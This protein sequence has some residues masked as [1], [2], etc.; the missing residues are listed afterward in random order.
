MFFVDVET[1]GLQ[2]WSVLPPLFNAI[3]PIQ[4][5]VGCNI[6]I[7]KSLCY[8]FERTWDTSGLICVL[9][10]QNEFAVVLPRPKIFVERSSKTT[11]VQKTGWAWSKPGS[12]FCH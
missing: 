4:A 7:R 11:N 10:T 6:K 12:Y 5:L 2:I 3:I 8:V 9:D 1:L